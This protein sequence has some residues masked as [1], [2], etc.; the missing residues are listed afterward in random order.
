M[1]PQKEKDEKYERDYG[2][3]VTIDPKIDPKAVAVVPRQQEESLV[4]LGED[5]IAMAPST[6]AVVVPDQLGS[7]PVLL[8]D[9]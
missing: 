7:S 4:H 1:V 9:D 8:G 2:E 3:W 5:E 6:V